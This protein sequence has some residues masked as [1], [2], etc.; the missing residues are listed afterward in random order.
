MRWVAAR[1]K[2]A[3]LLGEVP[4]L[5][6]AKARDERGALLTDAPAKRVLEP[7]LLLAAGSM[8]E[9]DRPPELTTARGFQVILAYDDGR[10]AADSSIGVLLQCPPNL[11][12]GLSGKTAYLW[13][14]SERF[15]IGQFDPDGKAIGSLPA[16][17]EIRVSD[18]TSGKVQLETP[19][20]PENS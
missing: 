8:E 5:L 4:A 14:G 9:A 11:I 3:L 20:S 17:I 15:E 10:T 2:P 6:T 12:D 7:L 1:S 16:G 19:D 13:S 18:F